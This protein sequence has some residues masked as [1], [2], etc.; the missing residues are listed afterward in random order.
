MSLSP[1]LDALVR[2]QHGDPFR[3]LGPHV[4]RAGDP[5]TI[6]VLRPGARAVAVQLRYP[7]ISGLTT[8]EHGIDYR[9]LVE[10][11][12]GATVELDDPYRFGRITTDYDLHLFGEGQLLQ[13]QE[14][15]GAHPTALGGIAGVHFAVWAPNAQR[16]SVVGDS[17][18]WDGRVHVMR[19]LLPS[20]VWELFIPG[21]GEGGCCR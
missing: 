13:V 17:N 2:G 4:D 8:L 9:L 1:D 6:R 19:H 15:L 14:R 21:L 20:G 7:E 5:V 12:G 11:E 16:V 18:G 10:F 3:L